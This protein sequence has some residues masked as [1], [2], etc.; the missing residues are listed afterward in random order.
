M[1]YIIW[2]YDICKMGNLLKMLVSNIFWIVRKLD[3]DL[4]F[5]YIFLFLD[6]FL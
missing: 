4:D 6:N 3:F 1:L 5:Y 2:Y